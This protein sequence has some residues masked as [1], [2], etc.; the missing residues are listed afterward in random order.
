[1]QTNANPVNWERLAM[2]QIDNATEW[3]N[4]R[5]DDFFIK[6]YRFATGELLPELRLHYRTMGM[7]RRDVAGQIVN[8]V[9]LLHKVTPGLAPIGCAPRSPTRCTA[10]GSRSMRPNSSSSCKTRSAAVDRRNPRT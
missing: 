6:D 1:M 4:Y 10:R 7:P 3:P 9:L 2:P 8:G 5:E